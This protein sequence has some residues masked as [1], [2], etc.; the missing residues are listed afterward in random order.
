MTRPTGG[1]GGVFR[2]WE[3]E[4]ERRVS[5]N[6]L[7][8]SSAPPSQPESLTGGEA[9]DNGAHGGRN[10]QAFRGKRPSSPTRPSP[11]CLHVHARIGCR[12]QGSP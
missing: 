1:D 10:P 7:T 8:P 2:L 9:A 6:P 5:E 4:P 12:P 11:R 3:G